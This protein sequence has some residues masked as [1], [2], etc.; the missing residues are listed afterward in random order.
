MYGSDTP[1]H[2]HIVGLN[3]GTGAVFSVLPPQNA[4][5]NWI[6][7]VQRIPVRIALDPEEVRKHPL[8]LGLSVETDA[9]THDRSGARLPPVC[10]EKPL[11]CTTVFEN[12]LEGVD[13]LIADIVEQNLFYYE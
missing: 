12:E 9:D 8:F 7:I 3:P 10:E 4:T 2:G 11:Y 5:G 6:K 13:N 1:F